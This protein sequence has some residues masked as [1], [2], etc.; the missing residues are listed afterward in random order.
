VMVC[1]GLFLPAVQQLC[2]LA[3][4]SSWHHCT[5]VGVGGGCQAASGLIWCENFVAL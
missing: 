5:H 1:S 3:S 2:T 4:P